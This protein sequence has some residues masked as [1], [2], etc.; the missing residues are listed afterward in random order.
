MYQRQSRLPRLQHITVFHAFLTSL[1]CL[2]ASWQ[3]YAEIVPGTIAGEFSVSPGGAAT[4]SVPITVPPG[5]NGMQPGLSLNYS[6]QNGN[7]LVGIGWSIGGLSV[8]HRCGAT[9]A[10]DGFKGGVNYDANDRFCLDGE[11]LINIAGTNEFRTQRESWQKI[12]ASGDL[13]NPDSFSV[14]TADGGTRYYGSTPDSQIN[15]SVNAVATSN[16]RLWAVSRIQ[17]VFEN[18]LTISYEEHSSSADYTGQ[19]YPKLIN[20]TGNDGQGLAPN[21]SVVF[22][23][24]SVIS[25]DTQI[26]FVGGGKIATKKR[27]ASIETFIDSDPNAVRS[28]HLTYSNEGVV[29]RAY[30]T[31]IQECGSNGACF[32]STQFNWLVGG[33]GSY[34]P[35]DGP[36]TWVSSEFDLNRVRYGD[37][38][39]DG[40]TDIYYV[41]G[42]GTAATD[43][44]WLSNGDGTYTAV[45]GAPTWV[46]NRNAG[47]RIDLSRINLSD[48]NGD[49]KTDIYYVNGWGTAATD[50]IWLS[51]GDGTY[52][53]VSG[54]P[55]WVSANNTG[56]RLDLKRIRYGDFNGDGKTDIY[57]VNG[58]GTAATDRVWLSNGDGT[59]TEVSGAPTWVS[60]NNTGADID[61]DRVRS[62]DFN[63]DGKTDI[64]YVNGWGTGATDRVWLSNGDG[65][66]SYI[67]GAATWVSANNT[68]ALIDL[69]RIKFGDFN[70][71]G[72]TDIYYTLG[73]QSSSRDR[74]HL[75]AGNGN[76]TVRSGPATWIAGSETG[77]QIDLK[78]INLGDFNADGITDVYYVDGWGN[79][80]TDRVYL[81]N[82][83]GEYV[84]AVSGTTTWVS[85]TESAAAI[86]MSRI[87]VVDINGDGKSDIYYTNG[88]ND[89]KKDT[90]HINNFSTLM[91][92]GV[93][94]GLG[95][96]TNVEYQPLTNNDVYTRLADPAV[97]SV[98]P[99]LDAQSTTHVV[100]SHSTDN[101]LG[102]AL[103][104]SY[105]YGGMKYNHLA[106]QSLGYQWVKITDPAGAVV[107]T[108]YN[109]LL[110]GTEGTV[111]SS[112]TTVKGIQVSESTNN[113][114][115]RDMGNGRTLALLD[116]SVSATYEINNS[117][118]VSEVN[119]SSIYDAYGNPTLVT[120]GYHDGHQKVTNNTYSP[121]DEL[122][123]QL[124]KLV[125]A[126][127]TSI[128]PGR[129]QQSRATKFDYSPTG[130]LYLETIEPDNTSLMLYS[131]H[132]YDAFGNRTSTWSWGGTTASRHIL[133]VTYDSRG[134]FPQSRRNALGHEESYVYDPET[135]NVLTLTGPNGLVT[136]WEYDGFGTKTRELRADGNETTWVTNWCNSATPCLG[137]S[138]VSHSLRVRTSGAGESIQIYDKFNRVVIS[139]TRGQG[140]APIFSDNE[141]DH[142]GRISQISPP[143]FASSGTLNNIQTTYDDLNRVTRVTYPD[144]SYT[145]TTYAGLTTTT[146]NSLGQSKTV[147][148]NSQGKPVEVVDAAGTMHYTYDAFGNLNKVTDVAGNVVSEM[149]YDIRGRKI[150]MVDANMGHWTY[151]Y[152][153]FGGLVSQTDARGQMISMQ[154]DTLGRIIRRDTPEGVYTWG[155]DTGKKGK[156]AQTSAPNAYSKYHTYDLLARLYRVDMTVD[157]KTYSTDTSYDQY[158]RV[159]KIIYPETAFTVR[160]EYDAYG[161][162]VAVHNDAITDPAASSLWQL[163]A[164]GLD[165]HGRI[166]KEVFGNGVTGEKVYDPVT[167]RL[168]GIRSYKD[169]L[170]I[171]DMSYAIDTIGNLKARTDNLQGLTEAYGYDDLNRLVSVLGPN[172]VNSVS[173]D[174]IGNILSKDGVGTYSYASTRP[175]AVTSI[176]NGGKTLSYTYDANGNLINGA[177]RTIEYTS[178]NKPKLITDG[179]QTAAY[180]YDENNNRIMQTEPGRTK[181]YIG[182]LYE[183]TTT[184]K[185]VENRHYLFAGGQRVGVHVTTNTGTSKT[186]YFHT[187]HLGSTHVITD[188]TGAVVE[189][190]SFD[191][192]GVRRNSDWSP[193]GKSG[194]TSIEDRGFTGHEHVDSI[195]LINMNARMYDPVIGRFLSAD[196]IVPGVLNSQ[197][198]NRYSY[199][200]NNPLKYTDPSGHAPNLKKIARAFKNFTVASHIAGA[201]MAVGFK[202]GGPVGAIQGAKIAMG[203]YKA[204]RNGVSTGDILKSNVKSF[205]MMGASKWAFGKVGD[206]WF[207]GAE[208]V[209]AHAVVG[210][211]LNRLGGGRF[212]DGFVSAGI[213]QLLSPA[214]SYGSTPTARAIIAGT[215]G[216]A[217]AH[218]GGGD[219]SDGF[220]T[221]AFARM[222]GES[223]SQ[224]SKRHR[225]TMVAH[226]KDS[227]DPIGHAFVILQDEDG[228]I[229][230]Y[231]FWPEDTEGSKSE[232][233]NGT[234]GIVRDEIATGYY[235]AY[236]RGEGLNASRTL[237]VSE[238]E[239]NLAAAAIINYAAEPPTYKLLTTMCA[240]FTTNVAGATGN[241]LYIVGPTPRTLYRNFAGQIP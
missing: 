210:G 92:S 69:A 89:S 100:S 209:A 55:T 11:R 224:D 169:G 176:V 30:V 94:N 155:Y 77:A 193:A 117:S 190:L 80:A 65:T 129:P 59:Y 141:Y 132:K 137:G 160:N 41:N 163:P 31:D 28:Y 203:S 214:I 71:D 48:F 194:I 60:A 116:S 167:N 219:F 179:R 180:Q 68:G 164:G 166:I 110:D 130:I 115:A 233:I 50:R 216:G 139:I 123:W 75:S 113:W 136:A 22:N 93:T 95:V 34:S 171:Q 159:S 146:T 128:A 200:N 35:I 118:L 86:D 87:N 33:G 102:G 202:I 66:Y 19:Y 238:G 26:A 84:S 217:A 61:L 207:I 212:Q 27:L 156:L 56:A 198:H 121:A 25:T 40:K 18:Y 5:T 12:V 97:E 20:Y 237:I 74:V 108:N 187:D 134:Q 39:G 142:L 138:A 172:G 98:Y 206:N 222:Y 103:I 152:D 6:N 2:F 53:E 36:A 165:A 82:A 63:G 15:A 182:A 104:T 7:G 158:G 236:K 208:K 178:F 215:V 197:A 218:T 232:Y 57:Y 76:Y 1:F 229:E 131:L 196:T 144:S 153:D 72:K 201:Y 51:S 44:V 14:Y 109:Q 191:A 29:G 83:N 8:I 226:L 181:I 17:D 62:G 140:G 127:V 114:I 24:D 135:G 240:T 184:S 231:G 126:E 119:T 101:G 235:N 78:R 161:T 185:T 4:Y 204:Y 46:S 45:S 188:D 70:G 37:F 125:R 54:A 124:G 120:V 221:A 112:V 227:D 9:I 90:V 105:Q 239:F 154:Y 96:S 147:T 143:Y 211:T 199:V 234:P 162:L 228:H 175:H 168:T 21:S 67:N 16:I 111:A 173:Y 151:Q 58:W 170:G 10:I 183:K 32:S 177:G 23:Y 192:W 91:I 42:W 43:T 52:T 189:N 122:S 174:T 195:G 241:S 157:G 225:I 88:W 79:A 186:R 64:Y 148:K 230:A 145:E 81:F 149:Q 205:A 223:N 85:N 13:L 220:W 73:W 133:D 213:A 107:T 49:G 3:T 150:D 99:Y 106:G 47:A 38:N